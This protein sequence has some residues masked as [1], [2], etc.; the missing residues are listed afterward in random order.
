[1]GHKSRSGWNIP[2]CLRNC[3]TRYD[4]CE[5]D[6]IGDSLYEPNIVCVSESGDIAEDSSGDFD[7]NS[8]TP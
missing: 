2:V 7:T 6:C 8:P 3:K 4:G 1:M 5:K